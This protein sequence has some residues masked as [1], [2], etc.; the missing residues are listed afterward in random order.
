[1][2]HEGHLYWVSD[3]GIANCVDAKTGKLVY[4]QRL[5]NSGKVYASL[6]SVEG[7]LYAVSRERGT[8]VLAATPEFKQLALNVIADDEGIFNASPVVSRGQ[9]LLRSDR[10]LYCIGKA[11]SSGGGGK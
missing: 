8:F 3:E 4:K 11:S 10:F 9:L 7:R 6:V 5:P 2:Y 1:M